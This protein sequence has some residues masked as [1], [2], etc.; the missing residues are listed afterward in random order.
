MIGHLMGS[1][2]QP[3]RAGRSGP[4]SL[5]PREGREGR[6]PLPNPL[7][8]PFR[9]DADGEDNSTGPRRGAFI[10]GIASGPGGPHIIGQRF[11]FPTG[12]RS[13]GG[14]DAQDAAA[15]DPATYAPPSSRSPPGPS[16][17]VISITARP[18]QLARILGSIFGTMGV[19]GQIPLRDNA[20]NAQNAER[21]S[22]PPGLQGF[23]AS[24]FN[25][26]NAVA[27]DAVYSQEALDRIISALMEQHPTSNA[28]GPASEEAI[29][30]LPKK[31]LDEQMLGPEL[32][33]EC[34]VCM[35]DVHFHDE[36]VV[37]PC[38][39]WFHEACARA[40]LCEHNTCPICRKGID[41]DPVSR[42]EGDGGPPDILGTE[43]RSTR[44]ADTAAN[45]ARRH[46]RNEA[47]LNSIRDR[48]RLSPPQEGTTRRYQTVETIRSR[49]DS[50]SPPAVSRSYNSS[51]Q[52]QDSEPSESQ[53]V[54]R[55]TTG[56]SDRS[57]RSSG[58]RTGGSDNS[59][60]PISWLRRL[61]RRNDQER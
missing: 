35:D 60:G 3:G 51:L 54:S 19:L 58:S 47:R 61:G 38:T 25:P 14:L 4:E 52:Y 1:G 50:I 20:P 9:E 42:N 57:Q 21:G 56:S 23:F 36:V 15:D 17:I 18:D 40:W 27:G 16:F 26:A 22:V 30:N 41:G 2:L 33:A 45:M 55:R 7:R 53:R 6:D 37:L 5:F 28:P 11:T 32:K 44:R 12:R 49:N 10:G 43:A 48:D 29:A 34:S 13:R 39:H 8:N 24:L 31:K 59:N 46:S